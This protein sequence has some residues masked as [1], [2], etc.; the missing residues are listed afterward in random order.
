MFNTKSG[1]DLKYETC[2]DSLLEDEG[3]FVCDKN[4]HGGA[5]NFGIS[6]RFL[7]N[8]ISKGTP[9]EISHY[10]TNKTIDADFVKKINAEFAKNIYYYCF[11]IPCHLD[12]IDSVSIA[13]KVLS[14]IVNLGAWKGSTLVQHAINSLRKDKVKIL[15]DGKIGQKTIDAINEITME[16]FLKAIEDY[17]IDYYIS[18]VEEEPTQA[19]FLK[20]WISRAKR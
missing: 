15:V 8:L 20:G 10:F 9:E 11:W 16:E 3:G 5:T 7:N 14:C 18:I 17:L 19:K 4:D 6:L 1:F 12:K 2:V 13:R